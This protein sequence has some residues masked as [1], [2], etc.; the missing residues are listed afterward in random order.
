MSRLLWVLMLAPLAMLASGDQP[1][2]SVDEIMARVAANQDRAEQ[3]RAE[4]VYQQHIHVA[5]L[6]TNGK[7]AREESADYLVTPTPDGTKKELKHIAGRYWHKGRY[8]AFQGEPV[9]EAGWLDSSLVQTFRDDLSN[10]KSKDGLGHDL[11]PLTSGEQK[12]YR[13]ELVGEDTIKGRKAYRVKFRPREKNEL[14]WAGEAMID[15]EEF[16][17]VRVY[18]KLSRRLPF[19]V[20]TL[21]GT[22]VPGIG[23]NVEYKR[24]DEGIWFR[25]SFGTE[26]RLHAVFFVNRDITVALQNSAFE[27]AK[28]QSKIL[29]FQPD[30]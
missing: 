9:P 28:V 21:L 16:E 4:Y 18:T 20:R 5:T 3:A 10:D 26:F 14:T 25:V 17:P 7:L 6:R 19:A 27:R 2:P 12:T 24:F 23:F 29:D 13:F 30:K 8:L 22:D 11:F 15:A 1:S